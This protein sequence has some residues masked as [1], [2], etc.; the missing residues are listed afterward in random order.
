MTW[1]AP[2][3][4]AGVVAIALP[5][6]IHLLGQGKARR[7]PFPSLQ[8]FGVPRPLPT[9]RT[10]LH[11]LLL[12][13]VRVAIVVAAV[14]A[15]ARPLWLTAARR[16]SFSEALA[17]A[18]IVDTSAS[19]RSASNDALRLAKQLGDSA[20]TS[21]TLAA[22]APRDA[23]VGA[24]AW[25][26]RQPGRGEVVIVS[27]FQVGTLDSTDIASI[28]ADVGVRLLRAATAS[29]PSLVVRSESGLRSINA[30]VVRSG[31][32][33]D[34]QWTA[35]GPDTASAPAGLTLYSADTDSAALHA[36]VNAAA[37]VGALTP[38][39]TDRS[40][41]VVYP[42]YPGR[43]AMLRDTTAFDSR[44]ADLVARLST[45]N[46]LANAAAGTAPLSAPDSTRWVVVARTGSHQPAIR[47]GVATIGGAKR[48][49]IAPYVSA[50][51][52][53]SATLLAAIKRALSTAPPVMELEPA[54]LADATLAQW[55]RPPSARS[56]PAP[57]AD[58]SDGRWFWILA[59][60][61]LGV[62]AVVRRSVSRPEI[63][64]RS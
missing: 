17:R 49:V 12:L 48:L 2:W 46:D 20:E 45:D 28:P 18:V 54:S 47:A 5:I 4:W 57:D 62:E 44:M 30:R 56:G 9:Q 59:L 21:I 64:A 14:A 19:M 38:V 58:L 8:F 40:I 16:S 42:G 11:D 61:L 29:T 27:D 26:R 52:L 41:A 50:G 36:A 37:S 6:L 10:R 24:V 63:V 7:L 55:Q 51:S 53:T 43:N 34:V 25:L 23:I 31:E 35:D 22:S 33:T 13:L 15:L 39:A 3:V 32:R 60:L 1:Q